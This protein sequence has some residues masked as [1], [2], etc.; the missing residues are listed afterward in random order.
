MAVLLAACGEKKKG[1]PAAEADPLKATAEQL[2]HMKFDTVARRPVDIIE[3]ATGK[4]GFNEDA[5]TPVLSPYTGRVV[6]LMAKPGDVVHRGQPLFTIDTPDIV[7]AEGDF[8]SGRATEAK[9][10]AVLA[11]AVRTRDRTQRLV[12]G[13]AAAQ[14]DLEQA[15]TDLAGAENDLKTAQ[16]QVESARQRLLAFNLTA[17]E[18]DQLAEGRRLNRVTRVLA[19]IGG[20]VVSRQVGPGQY[21]RPDSGNVLFTIADLSTMWLLAQVYETQV[22]MVQMNEPVRVQV[23]ALD[24]SWF[25]A[26]VSYIGPSVDP[27]TRRVPVR[28]VVQNARGLLRPEMFATFRFEET[29]AELLTVPEKAVVQDGGLQV[30]WVVDASN[31]FQRR[32]VDT[33]RRVPGWVEIRSGLREG[34]RVVTEGALFISRAAQI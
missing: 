21:V 2:Q 6:D 33:G 12:A 26:R 7:D 29:K 5:T 32:I 24:H 11:Q 25:P 19:P 28:C 9:A 14:K 34:E 3:E 4:V 16:A 15:Q 30:A 10:R 23:M 13:E 8:L 31:H 27:A 18:I 22:P 17:T 1:A 20:A